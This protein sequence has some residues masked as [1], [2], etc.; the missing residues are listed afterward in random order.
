LY[1]RLDERGTSGSV[2]AMMNAYAD[3]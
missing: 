2:P 1:Q 3:C